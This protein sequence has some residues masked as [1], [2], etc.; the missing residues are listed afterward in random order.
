MACL[1]DS[2]YRAILAILGG[3]FS[4][5]AELPP[6]VAELHARHRPTPPAGATATAPTDEGAF[7]SQGYPVARRSPGPGLL[8]SASAGLARSASLGRQSPVKAEKSGSGATPGRA[9]A[10][11]PS[12]LGAAGGATGAGLDGHPAANFEF[13]LPELLKRLNDHCGLKTTV[14]IRQAR[15]RLLTAPPDGSQPAP[16]GAA[17]LTNLWLAYYGTQGGTL[18]RGFVLALFLGA[19][20]EASHAALAVRSATHRCYAAVTD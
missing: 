9:A 6:A 14:A 16:L 2:E 19:E 12:P 4:E 17:E 18:V 7:S 5:Q 15:L 11:G 20:P 13:D 10:R 1:L 8:R 3:N